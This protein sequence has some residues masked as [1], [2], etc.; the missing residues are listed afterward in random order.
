MARVTITATITPV[1]ASEASLVYRDHLYSHSNFNRFS[2]YVAAVDK[3]M[4][5]FLLGLQ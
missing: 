2:H 4:G 1:S 3:V 5:K